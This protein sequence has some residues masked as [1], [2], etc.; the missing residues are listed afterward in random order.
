M[1]M[2]LWPAVITLGITLLRLIGE[3]QGWDSSA[4]N[5]AAGG[6]FALVGISW[7]PPIFGAYFAWRLVK[8]GRGPDS[9]W[10]VAGLSLLALVVLIAAGV[11]ASV[12]GVPRVGQLLVW[13]VGSLAAAAFVIAIWKPL[14]RTLLGYALA[15]RIPVAIVML[16]AIFGQWGTHYDVLPPDPPERLLSA[17]PFE[18]WLWIGL[19]PQMT[20]WIAQTLLLGAIFGGLAAALS[21]P[22][23]A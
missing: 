15:A 22:K 9:G 12:I 19:L 2:I 17:G 3:L 20:I 7:L 11:G 8:E 18:V 5:K 14:G 6:G 10:K 13:C 16:F 23:T 1:R 4:F 21:K